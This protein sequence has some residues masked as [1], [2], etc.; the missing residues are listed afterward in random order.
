MSEEQPS[1]VTEETATVRAQLEELK[2]TTQQFSAESIKDGQWFARFVQMMLDG[3]AKEI[4]AKGGVDFFRQKYPGLLVDQIAEKLCELATKY[5]ALAGAASGASSSAAVIATVGTGGLGGAP[6]IAGAGTALAVEMFYTTRLQVRLVYDLALLYGYP[7]DTNDPEDL[8]RVFAKA[9][10]I[11]YTVGN[12]GL[13]VKQ[14]GLEV[15]RAQ[16]RRVLWGNQ[17]AI[18][19]V[20]IRILGPRIGRQITQKALIRSAI[21]VVGIGLS[22]T[23]NYLSTS[24]I[25]KQARFDVAARARLRNAMRR[26]S[27][28]LAQD[29]S[30]I[31]YVL[32]AIHRVANADGEFAEREMELFNEV[33]QAISAP[34]SVREA[35]EQR[36][37]LPL[38]DTSRGLAAIQSP[39]LRIALIEALSVVAVADGAIAEPET[40]VLREFFG[41]LQ[42]PLDEHALQ[43]RAKHFAA[44][45]SSASR[46]KRAMFGA[47]ASAGRAVA[48]AASAA[49]KAVAGFGKSALGLFKKS[50]AI[51][52]TEPIATEPAIAPEDNIMAPADDVPGAEDTRLAGIMQRLQKVT[53]LHAA[54]LISDAELNVQRERILGEL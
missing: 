47:S 17:T 33:C 6:A 36:L 31:G 43:E 27:Q 42:Q 16:L 46:A 29:S 53:D 5:A 39:E 49:G 38:S 52:P 28:G 24:E 26:V 20:A 34:P 1:V 48:G 15:T 23:W 51:K 4:I 35:L 44:P 10:G 18:Q 40:L 19:Q 11:T 37:T 8:M 30:N 25:A 45:E 21:P 50:D 22:A 41:A 54:K 13:A 2:Q 9:Y 32:E 3:Y 7:I 12:V 14:G